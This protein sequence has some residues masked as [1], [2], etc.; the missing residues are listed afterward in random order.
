MQ[1]LPSCFSYPGQGR[2]SLCL[3]VCLEVGREAGGRRDTEI[4]AWSCSHITQHQLKA[5][6][7][8][9]LAAVPLFLWGFCIQ[10][11]PEPAGAADRAGLL[12][13]QESR[14]LSLRM[15]P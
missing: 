15:C 5:A 4:L 6:T 7:Q 2:Q 3:E 1:H 14:L 11:E 12:L 9:G 10:L 13:S 8:N